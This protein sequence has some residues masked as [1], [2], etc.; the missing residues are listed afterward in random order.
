MSISKE[1][2]EL[3][4]LARLYLLQEHQPSDW[5]L[6]E[7]TTYSFFKK[8]SLS[9]KS[10]SAPPV[11]NIPA[12]I[13]SANKPIAQVKI[14]ESQKPLTR[15]PIDEK[16]SP[17]PPPP[18][19]AAAPKQQIVEPSKEQQIVE[20]SKLSEQLPPSKPD[21][22][23]KLELMKEPTP[24]DFSD[25]YA[26]VAERCPHLK[27]IDTIPDDALAKSALYKQKAA[28]VAV[29]LFE[30]SSLHH[31]FIFNMV[32]AIDIYLAPAIKVN[33]AGLEKEGSW[34]SF[35]ANS[36]LK[37]I[38]IQQSEL[39]KMPKLLKYFTEGTGEDKKFLGQV[40]VLLLSD[41]AVYFTDPEKKRLLWSKLRFFFN[42]AQ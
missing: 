12:E 28:Q 1:L 15:P 21:T 19:V 10:H 17:P 18:P 14:T 5:I 24:V 34:D 40:P 32:K 7:A 4:D 31:T 27:I 39:Q 2:I 20:S 11:K 9:A 37:L 35:L 22:R 26:V 36:E 33:A 30:T 42:A 16:M 3:A 38:V 41:I 29:L 25:L 6:S 8:I 23:I 13:V